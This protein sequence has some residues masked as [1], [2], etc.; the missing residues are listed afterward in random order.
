MCIIMQKCCYS[1]MRIVCR[2]S[3][4]GNCYCETQSLCGH[5]PAGCE[6]WLECI[7]GV[8]LAMLLVPA[9]SI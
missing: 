9:H 3:E 6:A 5:A 2:G 4:E 1:S 7:Y 8:F